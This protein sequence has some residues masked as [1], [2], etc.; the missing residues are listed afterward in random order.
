MLLSFAFPFPAANMQ[1]KPSGIGGLLILTHSAGPQSAQA[2]LAH[3]PVFRVE[4]RTTSADFQQL[5][6][7]V[8]RRL[9]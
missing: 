7:H 1:K 2:K 8:Y 5:R 9:F 3:L 6:I 4:E